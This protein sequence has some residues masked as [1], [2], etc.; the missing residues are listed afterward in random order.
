MPLP[1]QNACR[2]CPRSCGIDRHMMTGYCGMPDTLYVAR[3]A[4]HPWEEPPISG[5]NGS[6]TIFFA[7][8]NLRC[9]FCQNR[10]ISHEHIG[11]AI[12]PDDLISLM[13]DLQARGAHNINLV[14]PT[15]Y[16]DTIART[17]KKV[18][19]RL[20]I[21]VVWNSS[22]YESTETLAML[23]G[24]VDIFLP[25]FKYFSS[26]LSAAY[27]VAS[28]Y[29][30][31]ATEAVKTM[32]RLTG[33]S[34]FGENGLMTKGVIVRHLILPGC[35]KDSLAVVNHLA[36]VLP[37]TGVKLS[38]MRQYTPEFALDCPYKNL[39]RHLTDFEYRSVVEAALSLGF[40]GYTQGAD[41]ATPDFTPQFSSEVLPSDV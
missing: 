17:L 5:T 3:A 21:P 31:V 15:H 40:D 13:L 41:A 18:K 8:C 27:A 26:E 1:T 6:G 37:V 25:D 12:T 30:A 10:T 38:L 20:H 19:P 22:A 39:H 16:T 23:D 11:Q 34:T 9:V 33:K 7:G 36:T 14:T 28:D 35:R 4:L 2:L 24:L 32:Y 29:A